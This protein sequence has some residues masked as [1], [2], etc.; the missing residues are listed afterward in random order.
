[1]YNVVYYDWI[2]LIICLLE[3]VLVEVSELSYKNYI[4]KF[5]KRSEYDIEM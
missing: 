1:M 4:L 3:K 5:M 2:F